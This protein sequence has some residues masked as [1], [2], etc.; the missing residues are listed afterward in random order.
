MSLINKVLRDLD[1]R[2]AVGGS[3]PPSTVRAV[4]ARREGHEWFWRTVALLV[5]VALGW[6]A[7][8]VYQIQPRP[9]ATELAQAAAA[10]RAAP[11]LAQAPPVVQPPVASPPPVVQ[12]PAPAEPLR[13][14]YSIETSIG[15]P[16][17]KAEPKPEPK[18][19]ARPRAEAKRSPQAEK[20][21]FERR[22]VALTPVEKAE[23]EFRRGVDLLKRGRAS[24]A[25]VAFRAALAADSA[26]RGA[27][28]AM[29]ALRIE[30]G[31][32]EGASWLLKEALAAD[33]R[34]PEFAVALAR[35]D[36]E[37]GDLL[38][39]LAVLDG[40]APAAEAHG[41][42]HVLRG[43]VLQR[44][45]R[46]AEATEAYRAALRA[47]AGTPQA[48]LGLGISLE[49]LQKRPEAAQAFRNAL[50]SGPVSAEVKTYAEQRIQALR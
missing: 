42:L 46:H 12:S 41:D 1:Q 38:G 4:A 27:R 18:R 11:A 7:W 43:T 31:D 44:L 48:W 49:A 29:V 20:P 32:L 10:K 22:E 34:Q 36:V 50:A 24:E 3:P 14:A 39:A 9:L 40:V 19:E 45:G 33:A 13:F 6:V 26:H 15:A 17:A 5:A 2:Q 23:V 47:Q 35:I 21:R 16:A 37:R 8:V 30:R 25:D 28:Q